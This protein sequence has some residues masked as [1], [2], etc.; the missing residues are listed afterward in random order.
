MRLLLM[1]GLLLVGVGCAG[2]HSNGALWS[3]QNLE[4]E[5]AMFQLGEARRAEQARAFEL[6]VADEQL[7]NERQRI[8][9]DLQMCP[10]PRQPLTL[11]VG[12]KVRDGI[13]VQA[14]GDAARLAQ[15]A[16]IALAD[17]YTRR[18]AASGDAAFCQRARLALDGQSSGAEPVR[19][20]LDG[21]P[22]VTVSRGGTASAA[23][24][25]VNVTDPMT[26]VSEYALGSLDAVQAPAPLP[27]YLAAVYGGS[28]DTGSSTHPDEEHAQAEVDQAAAAYPQ[29]EPDAL[30]AALRG[31]FTG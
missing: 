6:S 19:D 16:S 27:Q 21:L 9:T 15:V 7:A 13:R 24:T 17:W 29:W 12:D 4:Q 31:G 5:R 20:I 28:V 22:V 10:G 1:L 8:T 2:P 14:G 26:I 18:A 11:S 30:Y 3:E 23:A 25:A